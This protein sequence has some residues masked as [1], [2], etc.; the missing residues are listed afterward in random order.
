MTRADHDA[1]PGMPDFA[2]VLGAA[3]DGVMSVAGYV[4][5]PE[6]IARQ[7]AED[8]HL[9]DWSPGLFPDDVAGEFPL[10]ADD[11]LRWRELL[12]DDELSAL[13]D[14]TQMRL[15]DLSRVPD[16]EAMA[17]MIAT[18]Y[19]ASGES[20]RFSA[21]H[22]HPMFREVER[23][24]EPDR[25]ALRTMMTDL[26][27]E[28]AV[29][30]NLPQPWASTAVSDVRAGQVGRWT[31]HAERIR[32]LTD[33]A[34]ART[35]TI[36]AGTRV[37][38]DPD[39]DLHALVDT[40]LDLRDHLEK[41]GPLILEPDGM[42]K[43]GVL[44]K[45]VVKDARALFVGA[46]V[47]GRIPA[48]AEDVDTVLTYL[49]ARSRL[50][51]LDRMW[52]DTD[53]VHELNL[54][55]RAQCRISDLR[56][57]H[58][59]LGLAPEIQQVHGFMSA[60]GLSSPDWTD[61][62]GVANYVGVLDAVDAAKA[63]RSHTAALAELEDFLS[64]QGSWRDASP[65]VTALALA[66]AARDVDAYRRAHTRMWDLYRARDLISQRDALTDAVSDAAPGLADAMFDDAYSDA[67]DVCLRAV[68]GAWNWVRASE[69]VRANS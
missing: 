3:P 19:R 42:P 17:E 32:M 7:T 46:R 31:E 50:D 9:Y 63:V 15:T 10:T 2:A 24:P 22:P 45:R 8:A 12:L 21:I 43:I 56:L 53:P 59:V 27:E 62:A 20:R 68:P 13:E 18:E 44:S 35:Q 38:I 28:M 58:R 60:R 61:T 55:D 51:A 40:A 48:T 64:E 11:L 41:S 29:L 52:S 1:E 14:E 54:W 34:F 26:A 30:D 57:L 36:P 25:H 37:D 23:L 4:G 65:V 5:S 6:E 49:A 33:D 16:P 47:N 67:W 39:T 66:V 69:W